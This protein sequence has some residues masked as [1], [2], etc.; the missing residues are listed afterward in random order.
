MDIVVTFPA[1]ITPAGQITFEPA[2]N[3]LL[4]ERSATHCKFALY[5]KKDFPY[6]YRI[7]TLLAATGFPTPTAIVVNDIA[8][9]E[10]PVQ[11]IWIP[12]LYD[13]ESRSVVELELCD[14]ASD[15]NLELNRLKQPLTVK[16]RFA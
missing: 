6:M 11:Q 1:A 14:R 4:L 9:G 15:E 10:A 13:G 2:R 5:G 3:A 8:V 12:V 16:L 7:A